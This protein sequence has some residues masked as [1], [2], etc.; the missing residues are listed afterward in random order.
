MRAWRLVK[1]RL[2]ET[3]FDGRGAQRLGGRW[4]SPGLRV[5]YA[6]EHLSLAALEVLVHAQDSAA[7]RGY[8]AIAIEFDP[9]LAVDVSPD[10]LSGSWRAWPAP[11][12]LQA[13]G[14]DWIRSRRS[15]ILRV[16]STIVPVECNLLLNPE[17][18]EFARIHIEE[19]TPFE[20]D[21]RLRG[22]G[23]AEQITS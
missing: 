17:H 19:Q 18:P 6:S 14:D 1:T 3:A 13:I 7:L 8:S 15:A 21:A 16:P 10:S 12:A 11:P 20:L 22:A 2:A 9:R 23:R 5:V 4:N